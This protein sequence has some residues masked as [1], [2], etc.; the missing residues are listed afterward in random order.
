MQKFILLLCIFLEHTS[1]FIHETLD[2]LQRASRMYFSFS[3]L[4]FLLFE[5]ATPHLPAQHKVSL[6]SLS[7][8]GHAK[9]SSHV[10]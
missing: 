7:P 9:F 4:S 1:V 6:L 5:F 3:F 8:A 10:I 2:D